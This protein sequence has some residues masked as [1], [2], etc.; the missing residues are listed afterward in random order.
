MKAR[1]PCPSCGHET[2]ALPQPRMREEDVRLAALLLWPGVPILLLC[3]SAPISVLLAYYAPTSAR[4]AF[5]AAV[6][7]VLAAAA[8]SSL[9]QRLSRDGRRERAR[10][11]SLR[12][13]PWCECTAQAVHGESAAPSRS[14]T[15][16]P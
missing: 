16:R 14:R 11:D 2:V 1:E 12:L 5:C 3:A 6:A 13:C 7:L 10:T 15:T 9:V 4:L 8:I